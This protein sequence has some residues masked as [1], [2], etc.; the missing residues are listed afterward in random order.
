MHKICHYITD[1]IKDYNTYLFT[2]NHSKLTINK[3]KCAKYTCGL[4]RCT[5]DTITNYDKYL[6]AANRIWIT[7]D[8]DKVSKKG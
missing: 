8:K 2:A 3:D 4:C 5:L 1:N 6:F 7:N